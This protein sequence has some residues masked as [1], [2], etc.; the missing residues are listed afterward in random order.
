MVDP[1]TQYPDILF[2]FSEDEMD[3]I[4]EQAPK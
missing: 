2:E 1:C 4:G 3:T